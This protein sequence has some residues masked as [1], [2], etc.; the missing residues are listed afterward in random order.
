MPGGGIAPVGFTP[1]DYIK[2]DHPIRLINPEIFSDIKGFNLQLEWA[3]AETKTRLL[4][5]LIVA[6]FFL[7][8]TIIKKKNKNL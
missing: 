1:I 3:E 4:L 2:R 8:K 5:V 6:S 7:I